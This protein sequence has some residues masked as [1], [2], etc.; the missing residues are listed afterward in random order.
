MALL[1]KLKFAPQKKLL[2][3]DG[4]GIR[5]VITLQVLARFESILREAK[6][7]GKPNFRLADYFD[8]IGG[9]STGAIIAAAL[10]IGMSV[11]E[12][13]HFYD[14]GARE[15]FT[16]AGNLKRFRYMYVDEKLSALLR[17]VFG[18]ET[19]LGSDKLKTLVMTILRNATTDSPWPLSN[20]PCAKY[21]DRSLPDC[22]LNLPLWQLIRAS[23]AAPTYFPPERVRVG[24]QEFLSVDGGATTYNNPAFQ[25][26][27]MATLDPFQLRWRTGEDKLLLVSV[28]TGI[29]P[30][31]RATLRPEDM[32]LLYNADRIP[33]ALMFASSNEQDFLCRTFG[34]CLAG[35][36][37][38]NEVGD[39]RGDRSFGQSKL[40]TYLRYN[41]DLSE[42]G[43]LKSLGLSGIRPENVQCFDSVGHMAELKQIGR[44]V[45]DTQVRVE[46]FSGF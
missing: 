33:A 38:D 17:G 37:L 40:F 15:M 46:H 13:S 11:A 31:E 35:P 18:A 25:L 4:G 6:A 43:L 29:A 34:N 9:T 2:A 32:T 10:A 24:A 8:Y 21:N 45:A 12:I 22:N 16:R 36:L 41:A 1:D 44:V 14:T 23:T 30:V 7:E 20:N 26:F 39:M 19:T 3:I 5:G 27:L 28:G 42:K